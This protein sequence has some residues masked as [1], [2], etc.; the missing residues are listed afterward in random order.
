MYLFIFVGDASINTPVPPMPG[1]QPTYVLPVTSHPL[2][3]VQQPD[4]PY[5]PITGVRL[6][7][8][9]T[10]TPA[11]GA[12]LAPIAATNASQPT[13]ST[14]PHLSSTVPLAP[15]PD[16]MAQPQTKSSA[17]HFAVF[18]VM[19]YTLLALLMKML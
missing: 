18:N 5:D 19:T 16:G 10:D 2:N 9:P 15:Y 14:D 3:P 12:P 17:T 6:A 11:N 7:A 1:Q 13:L 8:L 4:V